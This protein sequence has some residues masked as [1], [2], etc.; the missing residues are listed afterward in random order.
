MIRKILLPLALLL[1]V[2]V[3]DLLAQDTILKMGLTVTTVDGRELAYPLDQTP[4]I[5]FSG[6]KLVLTTATTEISLLRKDVKTFSYGD[7]PVAGVDMPTTNI[8]NATFLSNGTLH[9]VGC[10]PYVLVELFDVDG[11]LLATIKAD[12]NGNANFGASSLTD[13]VYLVKIGSVS[14]KIL[15]K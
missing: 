13:G 12:D 14:Y 10:D 4:R 15:K 9:V 3:T 2:P 8:C 11:I 6:D 7:I 5:T 1:A